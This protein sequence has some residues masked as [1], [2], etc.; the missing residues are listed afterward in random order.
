[1]PKQSKWIDIPI[2]NR[3]MNDHIIATSASSEDSYKLLD[4]YGS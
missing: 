4:Q 3:G 1:M 2:F